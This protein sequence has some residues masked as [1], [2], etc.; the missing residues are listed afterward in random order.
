MPANR[1]SKDSRNGALWFKSGGLNRNYLIRMPLGDGLAFLDSKYNWMYDTKTDP[2]LAYRSADWP[3][4][5]VLCESSSI[6]A[7]AY[8]RGQVCDVDDCRDAGNPDWDWEDAPPCYKNSEDHVWKTSSH[9]S[10]GVRDACQRFHSTGLYLVQTFIETSLDM[11]GQKTQYFNGE[12]T[13]G[14]DIWKMSNLNGNRALSSNAFLRAVMHRPS[15]RVLNHVQVTCVVYEGGQAVGV[16]FVVNGASQIL[17]AW[18]EAVF[19]VGG[20][21]PPQSRQLSCVGDDALLQRLRISVCQHLSRVRQGL[22][23]RLCVSR[24]FKSNVRALSNDLY[25]PHDKLKTGLQ[26]LC[27]RSVPLSTNLNW[28]GAFARSRT[29]RV[30]PNLYLYSN[31]ISYSINAIKPRRMG[32]PDCFPTF[33]MSFNTC[34][35]TS[36]GSVHIQSPNPLTITNIFSIA[37]HLRD[38][39]DGSQVLRRVAATRPLGDV[40]EGEHRLGPQAQTPVQVMQDFRQRTDAVFSCVLHLCNGERLR[41]LGG[42][43][44]SLMR[45]LFLQSLT[46]TPMR[47]QLCWLNK[48]AT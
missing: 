13:K 25:S 8:V 29:D 38:V 11:G 44:A 47:P 26:Y 17:K 28:A 24:I 7:I 14:V 20:I 32:S 10:A 9:Q 39:F 2:T 15:P 1:L 33:S 45:R 34:R 22:Q 41:K 6:N 31:P 35:A 16:Q 4:G 40:E 46:E 30:H 42:G 43:C 21:T 12:H 23:D 18:K 36:R 5:S 3:R 19:G 27:S 37:G 48:V